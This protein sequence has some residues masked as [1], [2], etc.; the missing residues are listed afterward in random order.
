VRAERCNR[1]KRGRTRAEVHASGGALLLSE[2][3]LAVCAQDG[4]EERCN[5]LDTPSVSRPGADVPDRAAPAL[6][7]T[8]GDSQAHRPDWTQA[9]IARRVAQ[10]GGVPLRRQSW[11]GKASDAQIG[12]ERA[13]ALRATCRASP[14]PRSWVVDAKLYTEEH[15]PNLATRIKAAKPHSAC[16]GLG[17]TIETEP[18]SD[19]AGLAGDKAPSPAA[20]GGRCRNDP[21]C[22]VASLVGQTPCRIQGRLLVMTLARLV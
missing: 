18:R 13:P 5:P 11:A 6:A 22:F 8:P 1:V 9:V 20:G 4:L 17:P 21:W 15:A 19:A 10:D 3:V 7:S 2:L 12:Q 16:C 14:N